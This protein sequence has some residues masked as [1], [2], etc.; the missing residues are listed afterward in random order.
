MTTG[1]CKISVTFIY[2]CCFVLMWYSNS[3]GNS[4]GTRPI[5]CVSK[6]QLT[7]IIFP[8]KTLEGGKNR[9]YLEIIFREYARRQQLVCVRDIGV[10]SFSSQVQEGRKSNQNQ[11]THILILSVISLKF[12]AS[13][14]F[15]GLPDC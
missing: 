3:T 5:L 4:P 7:D 8:S 6:R 2:S 15:S 9:N 10:L 13:A 14:T 1:K 12:L 11:K